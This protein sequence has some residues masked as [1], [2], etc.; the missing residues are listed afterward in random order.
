METC[1][2]FYTSKDSYVTTAKQRPFIYK[3]LMYQIYKMQLKVP[4]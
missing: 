1:H 3:L 4:S 2:I